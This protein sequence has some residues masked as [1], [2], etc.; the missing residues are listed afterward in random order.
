MCR[1]RFK[2]PVWGWGKKGEQ[3]FFSTL[4][5]IE[6]ATTLSGVLFEECYAER[7]AAEFDGVEVP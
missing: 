4:L 5:R 6:V 2:S 3:Q 7:V 1:D